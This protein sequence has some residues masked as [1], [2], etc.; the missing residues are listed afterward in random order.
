MLY[1]LH[2]YVRYKQLPEHMRKRIHLYFDF[3]FE[4]RYYKETEILNSISENLRQVS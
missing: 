3:R 4:K 2:E 1:Q